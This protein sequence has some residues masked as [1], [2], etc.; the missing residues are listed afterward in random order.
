MGWGGSITPLNSGE[1]GGEEGK[2]KGRFGKK[3]KHIRAHG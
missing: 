2:K 1:K 3:Q